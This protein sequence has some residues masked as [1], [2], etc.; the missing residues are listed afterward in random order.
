MKKLIS[1]DGGGIKGIVAAYQLL[2]LEKELQGYLCDYVDL[3][4]GTSTGS[5][6]AA[7]IASGWSMEKILDLYLE[8]GPYIFRA[9][10]LHKIK[11]MFGFKGGKY[12]SKRLQEI[13]VKHFG[14]SIVD[15]LKIDFLATAYNMTEGKPRFFSKQE[16]KLKIADVV[17]ASSSA[18]TYFDPKVIGENEYIDGGTFCSNPA[19]SAFAE[20]KN[21]H[22]LTAE[23]I[24]VL[25]VGNGDR[26]H[27]FTGMKKWLK[28]KWVKPLIDILMSSDAGVVH[29]QLVKIYKSVNKSE[30]Y[31][32]LNSKLP[33]YVSA[34]MADASPKNLKALMKFAEENAERNK[35]KIKT[36][37][38]KLKT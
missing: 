18:P 6:L 21:L 8:E 13:L 19:M 10:R 28:F 4:A 36:I 22:N 25:S 31:W 17:E 33:D 20:I 23:E 2:Q 9:S 29:Y 35:K 32:R 7:G 12:E 5:I 1:I 38:A 3:A 26:S 24:F 30:N 11:S 34:D 16:G 15:D 37:A 14:D 27:G